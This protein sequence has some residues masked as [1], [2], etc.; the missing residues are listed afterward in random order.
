MKLNVKAK[1]FENTQAFSLNQFLLTIPK[2]ILPAVL[3]GI[4]AQFVS[5]TAGIVSFAGAGVLGLVFRQQMAEKITQLYISRNMKPLKHLT[6]NHMINVN[7]LSKKY[8]STTVLSLSSLTI[9]KGEHFGLVGNNGAGKTTLFSLI[10][11]L[12]Q[13]S[14]GEVTINSINV[15]KSE[16]WKKSNRSFCR[17]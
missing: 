15:A 6:N 16:A 11:D 12:I 17:R 7:N 14:S 5:P 2:M 10:L 13:A 4:P 8:G 3:Y 1:A 9:T